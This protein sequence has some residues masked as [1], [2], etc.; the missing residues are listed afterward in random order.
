M[1]SG[2]VGLPGL[3]RREY[4]RARYFA[5]VEIQ[6]GSSKLRART[7]DISLGGM[8]IETTDLLRVGAEFQA[9]ISVS[10]QAPLEIGCLVRQ[11]VP[12]V[13][14]GVEFVELKP[15]DHTRLRKLIESLPH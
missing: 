6:Y 11:V 10:G 15:A 9:R 13:G 3:D 4:F 14:M 12:N 5:D 1:G 7:Q 2:E 8:L